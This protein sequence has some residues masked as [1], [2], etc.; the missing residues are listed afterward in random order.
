MFGYGHKTFKCE[1]SATIAGHA[2]VL[3]SNSIVIL[4][5]IATVSQCSHSGNEAKIGFTI[6]VEIG[7]VDTRTL[8]VSRL[9]VVRA[10]RNDVSACES[11]KNLSSTIG[12]ASCDDL[13]IIL[14]RNDPHAR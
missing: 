7:R 4:G 5:A 13:P 14:H 12:R 6:F 9:W 11:F 3:L 1:C 8:S 10:T 2:Q